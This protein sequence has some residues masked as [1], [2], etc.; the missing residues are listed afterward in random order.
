MHMISNCWTGHAYYDFKLLDVRTITNCMKI[1]FWGESSISET[2]KWVMCKLTLATFCA[3]IV[4]D[5][6]GLQCWHQQYRAIP[7]DMTACTTEI[8]QWFSTGTSVIFFHN[9]PWASSCSIRFF[10]VYHRRQGWVENTVQ[11]CTK[12]AA[13]Q[14]EN[15]KND[16]LALTI[17]YW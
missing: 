8:S 17:S 9:L 7:N 13:S 5:V 15:C 6:L 10:S 11:C 16:S 3:K 12:V 14:C 4:K 1:D 2:I